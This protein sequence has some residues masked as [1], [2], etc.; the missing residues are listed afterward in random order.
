M[1]NRKIMRLSLTILFFISVFKTYSINPTPFYSKEAEHWADSTLAC[2]NSEQKIAQ[3]FMVDAFSNK[4]SAHVNG[5]KRL[6]EKYGIGGLIFFQGGPIREALLT[7]YY[8]SISNVPLLIGMDA[9][10]GLAM[11]IDSTIRFPRQMTM[12]AIQ[13]DSAVY[14]MGIEIAKHCK[15]LGIHV[16]FAPD[17]D[18][19][20]NPANP[21]IGSRSFG[22]QRELVTSKSIDYMKALQSQ[23]ILATGKHFPGHGNVDIDSHL[24]LPTIDANETEMDS[25]ELYPFSKMIEGGLGSMMVAHLNVPALEKTIDLPSTLSSSIVNNLL[26]KKMGFEGLIFTDA[27]NMKGVTQCFKPGVLEKIALIAGNDILLYSEDVPL[28]IIE[29]S[30]SVKKNELS[31]ADIDQKVKKLLMV[32]YWCG[33]NQK[34]FIDTT[35]LYNDLNSPT[36]RLL[37]RSLYE[38]SVTILSNTDSLLPFRSKDSLRIASVVIGDKKNNDFQLQLKQYANIEVFN[39]DKDAPLSVFNALFSYLENYDYVILSL[40]GTS[41]KSQS[42]YG[43]PEVAGKFIDNVL[44]KYKSVFTVFGNAYTLS[45]FKNLK[46]ARALILAYEDFPLV[47]SIAAQ[48]IMGGLSASGKLPVASTPSFNRFSGLQTM[49][50]IRLNYTIPEAVGM[51]SSILNQIDSVVKN[52]I[53]K[54]AMPGCQILVA[55]NGSVIYQKSFGTF[56]YDLKDTVINS[57]LYDIASITKIAA[58]SLATMRLYDKH[59]IELKTKISK[60]FSKLKKTNKGNLTIGEILSHNAGLKSWIPFYKETL[61]KNE[62]SASIYRS[63]NTDGYKIRVAENLYM[64]VSYK[65]T[66]WKRIIDSPV[67]EKGKYVYSDLGPI[68]M[69]EIIESI[70]KTKLNDFVNKNFYGPL[71]LSRTTFNPLDHFSKKEIVPTEKDTIFRKQLLQ[72]YVHDPAAA[73]FGGV[74]GNAGLFSNSNDLAI[75]LQMLL[76]KGNYGGQKFLSSET[77][78]EFTRAHYPNNR[79]GL[80]FDKPET[81]TTKQNPCTRMASPSTFGHQGFTGTCAWADPQYGLIYIF[82]SNRINPDSANDKLIKMNV[83]TTIQEIIYKAIK[84]NTSVSN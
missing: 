74:S 26:K 1:S 38:K 31:Q 46:S 5:V 37:Q 6:I 78:E 34:Q 64:N 29:I 80:L 7:N 43:I 14:K 28:A 47:H 48:V 23:N 67:E 15:R 4:D 84:D 54:K 39:E 22:D 10:W 57:S 52:A 77:I 65:D 44:S 32:K 58:T 56:T 71:N 59:K 9:E 70:T 12:S 40:H 27:L 82:L 30:N 66:I 50:P 11:R 73:M 63:K 3:L 2:L 60:N 19:N 8:Q 42:G 36:S 81:D 16:N 20:N 79:R 72:G 83:R 41:M 68:I 55:R 25:L 49:P 35:N 75:I 45:R 21:I 62:P 61:V 33:L 17:A 13:D 76:N 24:A 51:S 53:E 18:I 69:K